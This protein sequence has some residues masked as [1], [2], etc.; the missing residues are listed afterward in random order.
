LIGGN[1]I[2]HTPQ[3]TID[4]YLG[5]AFSL[6]GGTQT[7][8]RL[9]TNRVLQE[10]YEIKL[11]NRKDDETVEI[12]VPE[13]LFRWSNWEILSKS[14]DYTQLDS[15]TIEFRVLVEPGEEEIITYTVQ[16]SWP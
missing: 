13:H 5:N 8:Y 16:Y 2:D 4:L 11:R 10:T 14:H 1:C 12:R 6:V 7:D 9:V 15:N 3:A